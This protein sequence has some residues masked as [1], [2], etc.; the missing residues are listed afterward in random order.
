MVDSAIGTLDTFMGD[1]EKLRS[2][3]CSTKL[4]ASLQLSILQHREALAA[5]SMDETPRYEEYHTLYE[6][7]NP[8][9]RPS[10]K[11]ADE[12]DDEEEEEDPNAY[13]Y[14]YWGK[15]KVKDPET[16]KFVEIEGEFPKKRFVTISA[17]AKLVLQ[18]MLNCFVDECHAYYEENGGS[19]PKGDVMD[20]I[21]TFV[22]E[23]REDP[24]SPFI[25]QVSK[26]YGD[27]GEIM[28]DEK[29]K[30]TG[31]LGNYIENELKD[32][33][34]LKK[35]KSNAVSNLYI[36]R[37][38]FI[39][40]IKVLSINIMDYLWE[41]KTA[42]NLDMLMGTFRQLSRFVSNKGGECPESFYDYAKM[43]IKEN[44]NKKATKG[45][46]KGKGKGSGKGR[47]RPPSNKKKES[48][49]SSDDEIDEQATVDDALDA[50]DSDGGDDDGDGGEEFDEFD[51][52]DES[53]LPD[54]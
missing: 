36:I 23:Q 2:P 40:F 9:K 5:N 39:S 54:E 46:A 53:A 49:K 43:Y 30:G 28:E 35:S 7:L 17:Q 34:D 19:F 45:K 48:E 50:V 6:E 20:E 47:G 14:C 38:T 27:V 16:N 29:T 32:I 13:K 3:G 26:I 25:I 10:K 44:E 8:K 1:Y 51:E 11:D 22:Y 4:G 52:F 33:F 31:V 12:D 24:I 15:G 42:F 41:H 37:E 18:Y 21:K